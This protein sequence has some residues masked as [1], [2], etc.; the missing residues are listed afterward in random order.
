MRS[1]GTRLMS[2]GRLLSRPR[3]TIK[4]LGWILCW[5]VT[6]TKISSNGLSDADILKF[7]KFQSVQSMILIMR[8][9]SV[10]FWA[11]FRWKVRTSRIPVSK[12]SAHKCGA[13]GQQAADH[14]SVEQVCFS[15]D[16]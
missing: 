16:A 3:E 13:R 15:G 4:I 6:R 1:P 9:A 14:I 8:C 12:L 5:H 11:S 10:R 7:Q 2:Y